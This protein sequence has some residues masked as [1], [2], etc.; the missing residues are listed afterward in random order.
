VECDTGDF[1]ESCLWTLALNTPIFADHTATG[2]AGNGSA[3][4][5]RE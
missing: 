4:D 2:G 3:F 1:N 5:E